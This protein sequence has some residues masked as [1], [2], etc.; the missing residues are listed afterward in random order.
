MTGAQV[1]EKG[2]QD[3]S[4]Q[5]FAGIELIDEK[6]IE[7][8]NGLPGFEQYKSF[9]LAALEGYAPFYALKAVRA[10]EISMLVM[11]AEG[12]DV[13]SDIVIS[14][15][16]LEAIGFDDAENPEL[17]VVLKVD[18]KSQQFTANIKAPLVMNFDKARGNQIILEDSR[19]SV[20][21]PLFK[22]AFE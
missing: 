22:A 16:D 12:L 13:F 15:G 6:N 3:Q 8:L 2:T 17:F 7:L 11:H 19:L 10:P 14:R 5:A 9:T 4:V 1:E 18:H 20:E 21:Y